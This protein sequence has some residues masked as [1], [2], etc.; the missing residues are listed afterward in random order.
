[1]EE[2]TMK[3]SNTVVCAVISLSLVSCT[4]NFL[5]YNTNPNQVTDEQMQAYNYKVGAEVLTLQSNVVPVQEHSYQFIESLSACP[6]AGYIGEAALWEERFTTFNPGITWRKAV[7]SDVITNAYAPYRGIKGET[8]DEV[9]GAFASLFRVAI[10]HRLTDNF[11]PIPYSDILKTEDVTVKYDPQETVYDEMFAELDEAIAGLKNNA[12][13]PASGWSRYDLVYYGDIAKWVKYANS[14]KLRMAMRLSYVAPATAKAKATEAIAAGVITENADNAFMHPADNRIALIQNTWG[15]HRI[16]ADIISYMNGY[17]DPRREKMFTSVETEVEKNGKK[18][19]IT[20]FYGVRV[21]GSITDKD[22]FKAAYSNMIVDSSSPILW[23]NAAEVSFLMS[24]YELRW[25]DSAKAKELYENGIILSFED[26]GAAGAEEYI[27]DA[28]SRPESYNDPLGQYSVST[29]QS[30]ITIA[31]EESG[32][33][34][35]GTS[36]TDSPAERNLER[37]IT[38]KWLAIFPSGAEGWAEYRRT[39]YPRLLPAVQD[40]SGGTV[41]LNHRARRLIYP[42][43]EYSGN[44]ENLSEA[45]NQLNSESLDNS[46]DTFGTRV[47]W[48]KKDYR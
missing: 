6:F 26:K 21:G 17:S 22:A 48:D 45:V 28:K 46:G 43:E 7:F 16:A 5:E 42:A 11:G 9:S 47:W 13:I 20:G 37:I 12:G 14:L 31:W 40:K 15:D 35:D 29:P 19:T 41:D 25:G 10:M 3:I 36:L 33:L 34:A 2:Y 4:G 24:E 1:M 44:G 23:L 38:Q 30:E 18:E 39:G 32:N 8:D 27:A